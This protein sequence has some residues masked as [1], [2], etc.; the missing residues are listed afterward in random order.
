MTDNEWVTGRVTLRIGN[1][2]LDLEMTVPAK[3][4]KPHRTYKRTAEYWTFQK[5]MKNPTNPWLL[6][7]VEAAKA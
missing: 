7:R 5:A 4:V 6:T 1:V 2:P 3:P